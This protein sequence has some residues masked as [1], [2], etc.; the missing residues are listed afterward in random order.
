M[1]KLITSAPGSLMLMGE[2]A[3]LHGQPALVAAIDQRIRVTL[4][5]LSTP[6]LQIESALGNYQAPLRQLPPSQPLRFVLA[7]V[8]QVYL[9]TRNCY[10]KEQSD[11]AIST[12]SGLHIHIESTIDPTVGFGSSAALTVAL[13]GA[14]AQWHNLTWTPE[15]HLQQAR[16]IIQQVQGRGSGADIAASLH[17]GVVHY[18]MQP[19][20]AERLATQLTIA[21]TYCGYKTPTAEVIAHVDQLAAQNLKHYQA[22]YQAMGN[23]TRQAIDA[24]QQQDHHALAQAMTTYQQQLDELGVSDDMLDSIIAEQRQQPGVLAAKISGSGLGD[25]VIA[26]LE[27]PTASIHCQQ[28]T[29]LKTNINPEGYQVEQANE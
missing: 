12:Q 4:T 21:P 16:Q 13:T 10:R 24:L 20:H 7:C 23:T 11:A 14:L 17:G 27:Q 22:L 18:Q 5:P 25:C 19:L 8:A 15:Q 29:L 3:I 6:D 1:R 9:P 26:L 28:G 2:H